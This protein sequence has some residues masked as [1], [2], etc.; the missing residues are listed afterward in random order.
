MDYK[1]M[2]QEI[3]RHV[4]GIENISFMT[5]CATRLRLNFKDES[6]VDLEAVKQV[7]GVVGA[8]KKA[9]QYQI[10]IGT[11]V[12]RVLNEINQLGTITGE[13]SGHEKKE[14]PVN[15]LMSVIAGIFAPIIPALTAGGMVKVVLTLLVFAGLVSKE[16]QTY[17]VMNFIADAVFYFLPVLVAMSTAAKLKCNMYLAGVIGAVL[18]H[19]NFVALTGAGEPVTFIGLP[20]TLIS[21]GSSVIPAILAVWLMSVVEPLADRISPKPIKFLAKPLIT[22]L[23]VSPVTLIVLGPLGYTIGTGIAAG[24]DYLNRNVSW[25]VPTLMGAFMPLL[26]LTGMHWSFTPIIVQSYASYGCEAV[27]GPGSFVSNICQGAASLAVALKAKNKETRQVA[28][29]AG[30]TALLGVTEPA[31]FGVTLKLK[32]P[33]YA[34]M[35]GGACGGLYAGIN[36]VVRYTSGTPG[37]A[38][39]AIFIGENPMNLAHAFISV[40][41]GF[42]ITFVLTWILGF[43]E[44]APA[45][46]VKKEA[47]ELVRKV[48]IASPA[49]GQLIGLAQVKDETLASGILGKGAAVIPASGSVL[50]PVNGKV[51]SVFPTRHAVGIVD[52]NGVELLIHIGIDTVKLE[53]RYFTAHVK[54]GDMVKIGDLLVEFDPRAVTA[55][56]YDT[57]ITL[58]ITNSQEFLDVLPAKTGPIK[59]GQTILTVV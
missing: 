29:S 55:E 33:L 56:G 45:K 12:G 38:S 48:E 59:A 37:L 26:V 40:G 43:E 32:R 42:V 10:I 14:S 17:Y 51:I 1:Q 28:T 52:E 22:L 24:A 7:S 39:F 44:A 47:A 53:G 18:L 49:E 27:M 41:I 4:G 54:E 19:P 36:G 25:L 9:G 6:K 8:V 23:V 35:I 50:S 46:T 30:I 16:S 11:D 20:L 5:N 2:A 31:M 57:T 3:L 58:L 21:Y 34:V 15:R 13:S